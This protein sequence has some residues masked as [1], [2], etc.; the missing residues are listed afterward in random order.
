[1]KRE[2]FDPFSLCS[3]LLIACDWAALVREV[4]A[5]LILPSGQEVYLQ[6]AI[7]FRFSQD[8]VSCPCKLPFL[9][10]GHRVHF[11]NAVLSQVGADY[12]LFLRQGSMNQC[13]IFLLKPIPF[14]LQMTLRFLVLGEHDN[15]GRIAIQTMHDK[16]PEPGFSI[17]LA[18][19]V[20]QNRIGRVLPY[21]LAAYGQK[22]AN[23]VDNQDVPILIENRKPFWL[24]SF[25]RSFELFRGFHF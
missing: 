6:K 13:V 7:L 20:V 5:Y 10:I 2:P 24:V 4:H 15:A 17:S 9:G 18:D 21:L 23:L 22:P 25:R 19:V 1:M 14:L 12:I 8:S 11:V 3:I 16:Y